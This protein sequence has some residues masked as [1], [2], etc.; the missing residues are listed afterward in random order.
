MEKY[1]CLKESDVVISDGHV[2]SSSDDGDEDDSD[3]D[4]EEEERDWEHNEGDEEDSAENQPEVGMRM[5][6]QQ[7]W[8]LGN[9]NHKSSQVNT[10]LSPPISKIYSFPG[11][12]S[13][14]SNS[15]HGR[16]KRR[17][18]FTGGYSK[19]SFTWRNVSHV[20]RSFT[21]VVSSPL[22]FFLLPDLK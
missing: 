1:L 10:C 20:L 9:P 3:E 19:Y 8:T 4:E 18:A 16:I 6:Q 14:S 12:H 15:F 21:F 2:E 11:R 13:L 7:K 22:I 5:I 17:Y